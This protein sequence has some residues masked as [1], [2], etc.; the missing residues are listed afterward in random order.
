MGGTEIDTA[1]K[2]I[3]MIP[4]K[5][6]FPRHIFLLTD[7]CISNE[8]QVINLVENNVKN[9][10]LHTIGIGNGVSQYLISQCA[11]KGKGI[12]I[13]LEDDSD[14]TGQIIGL[15]DKA[16]SPYLDSF[17]FKFD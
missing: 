2:D 5:K 14:V 11:E 10:R 3:F 12:S 1:L 16:L 15:L 4:R 8:Q 7:G 9:S 17:D 6:Q 13:N